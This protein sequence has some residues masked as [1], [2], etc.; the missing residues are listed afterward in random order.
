MKPKKSNKSKE[1]S[2]SENL[3]G[4]FASGKYARYKREKSP[5][6]D[7]LDIFEKDTKPKLTGATISGEFTSIAQLLK[8]IKNIN[9]LHVEIKTNIQNKLDYVV[10]HMDK[11]QKTVGKNVSI[12]WRC[13]P[14]K[15]I[16]N[17]L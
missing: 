7:I 2:N 13:K 9:S 11:I 17:G 5:F 12:V 15:N 8:K 3:L 10:N 16:K 1:F 6:D 4:D 14:N